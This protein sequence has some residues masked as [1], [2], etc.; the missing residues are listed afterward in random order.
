MSCMKFLWTWKVNYCS[1][2]CSSYPNGVVAGPRVSLRPLFF[3]FF[4]VT[5]GHTTRVIL[6]MKICIFEL[7][8]E[9][10]HFSK[11]K[12]YFHQKTTSQLLG[13]I[14][15]Q[16]M[17][18]GDL[19]L[20]V[21]CMLRLALNFF[22]SFWLTKLR[23]TLL[24]IFELKRTCPFIAFQFCEVRHNLRTPLELSSQLHGP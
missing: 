1:K 17:K 19:P 10:N 14:G 21:W 20:F 22:L 6:T 7:S 4:Y 3:F 2:H 9:K 13:H 11:T 8:N 18:V 12:T 5:W 15:L 23:E 16:T 24:S